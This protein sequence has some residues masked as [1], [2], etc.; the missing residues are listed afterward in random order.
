MFERARFLTVKLAM[1]AVMATIACFFI[2]V[3]SA[4]AATPANDN[5]ASAEVITGLAGKTLGS[6]VAATLEPG[7][8]GGGASVWYRWVATEDGFLSL[9]TIGSDFDTTLSVFTGDTLGTLSELAYND[10]YLGYFSAIDLPVVSGTTYMIAVRGFGNSEG[11]VELSWAWTLEAPVA[12]ISGEVT[13]AD[14]A[15]INEAS[16][17][18]YESDAAGDWYDAGYTSTGND[19]ER[20]GKYAFGHLPEGQYKIGFYND[21]ETA[22]G[23]IWGVEYYNDKRTLDEADLLSVVAGKVLTADA[24]LEAPAVSIHGQVTDSDGTPIND[25]NVV[26]YEIDDSGGWYDTGYAYT[27]DDVSQSGKYAFGDLP[28]G[29]YKLSFDRNWDTVYGRIWGIEY[30]NNRRTLEDADSIAVVAGTIVTAN[31]VLESPAISISGKVTDSGGTPINDVTVRLYEVD[32]SGDWYDTGRAYTEN[33]PSQSGMYAFGNLPAGQYKISFDRD[34]DT[35]YGAIQVIEYY[36]DERTLEAAALITVVDGS[37]YT[38]DAVLEAP[39]V[40]ISGRVTDSDGAPINDGY[41]TLFESDG[42]GGWDA[43]DSAWTRKDTSRSGKYAFGNVPDGQYKIS[44]GREWDTAYGPIW[45]VEYYN[46]KRTL[47]EAALIT[48]VAGSISTA[49]AVLEAPV[50]SISGRVSN[51]GGTWLKDAYV[52]LYESDGLGGWDRTAEAYTAPSGGYAFHD[53]ADG[54]YKIGFDHEQGAEFYNNKRTLDEADVVTVVAGSIVTANAMLGDTITLTYIAGSGGSIEGAAFQEHA[55][56]SSGTAVTA[57]ADAGYRFVKWSDNVTSATRT[58][59]F[60]PGNSVSATFVKTFRLAYTPGTGCAGVAGAYVQLVDLN[61]NGTAVTAIPVAGYHFV[62][63]SDGVTANP[64]LDKAVTAD[65]AVSANF[66]LDAPV[67]IVPPVVID[68]PAIVP[69]VVPTVTRLA[70]AARWDVAANLARKGWDPAGTK[71]WPKVAHIIIANGENGKEADPLTAAGLAGAYDAPVLLTQTASLPAATKAIITEIARKN[72]RVR[73]HLIGGTASVPDARWNEIK[74]IKGVSTTKDRIAGANRYDVSANIANRIVS[75]KGAAAISGLILIAAD[76]PAAFYDALAA[77]PIAYAKTMPMLSVK[78]G[79]VPPS[80]AKVMNSS[81][82][83]NKKRYAASSATYIGA[84]SLSKATRLTNSKNRYTAASN[85]A[86]FAIA[87]NWASA[88]CVGLTAKLPDALT[89][90]A[91]LGKRG[92]VMLFT[93]SSKAIQPASKSFI[94][95]HKTQ[96]VDAC[97]M[98]GTGSVPEAQRTSL[99]NLLK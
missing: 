59:T 47:D 3:P 89:G 99:K 68:P 95:A 14:G 27:E 65:K 98:G 93:D 64:R 92:G 38:A 72:P 9:D 56:Y 36:N 91:Y 15:P 80:V 1:A 86:N 37:T 85:I 63:W 71:A 33:D 74:R 79:S 78:K 10:D 41:V 55:L 66:A 96:I 21:W 45:S 48:V 60:V 50:V 51:S 81:A 67:V 19:L 44:F 87:Q 11:S 4:Q 73:I 13:G 83:K 54:Q 84:G 29:Q 25:V 17:T 18:L 30:Y 6:N 97:V 35:A 32:D 7:E 53:V 26:L 94:T 82:L 31:A 90:S 23:P 8:S 40:S 16:V 75:L 57:K 52:S 28:D 49:D 77:S 20:P 61:T 70:G 62:N 46:D 2:A 43:I 58:D 5:F 34:W 76:N 12:P 42:F 88:A 69:P 22:Y 24:V 39:V